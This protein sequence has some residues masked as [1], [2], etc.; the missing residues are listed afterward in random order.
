M[1]L[2]KILREARERR[3]LSLSQVAA[4]TRMKVQVAQALE[5]EDYRKMPAPI[6][7][8]GFIRMYA[9]F[10]GVD[11]KPLIEEYNAAVSAPPDQPA[12]AS[13]SPA[14]PGQPGQPRV[15][16]PAFPTKARPK[17]P[18][19]EPY[20]TAKPERA[21]GTEAAPSE[22][23]PAPEPVAPPVQESA[24]QPEQEP[25]A[26]AEPVR[27]A[28]EDA[29][30]E[31]DLFAWGQNAAPADAPALTTQSAPPTTQEEPVSV[32]APR[33]QPS[34]TTGGAADT[35]EPEAAIPAPPDSIPKEES[36][37][38]SVQVA[39][40]AR[41]KADAQ[42]PAPQCAAAVEEKPAGDLFAAAP[43]LALP[44][45]TNL[46][47]YQQPP[48]R[49]SQR[50]GSEPTLSSEREALKWRAAMV[51]AGI[52][53]VTILL[54]SALSRCSAPPKEVKRGPVK[55]RLKLA[56]EPPAPYVD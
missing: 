19:P 15:R 22:P 28:A 37:S 53:V 14:K 29:R 23:V 8:R 43:E 45:K 32:E 48:R 40:P 35:P 49:L 4:A 13:P 9:A 18:T 52:V 33:P 47:S 54:I 1:A 30:R 17:Q 2:G 31:D 24:P 11:P 46:G 44:P 55:E 34:E 41:P 12:A 56:V 21:A 42:E 5:A 10:V 27:A 39:E 50:P 26:A 6:Y 25:P 51:I 3:Q 7:G 38:P 36:L 16:P 20:T